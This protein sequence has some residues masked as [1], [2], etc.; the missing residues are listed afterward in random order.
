[1]AERVS[2]DRI[3][4]VYDETRGLPPAPMA[5]AVSFLAEELQGKR[6]LEIGVGT[7]RYAVPLQKSAIEVVGVDIAARMVARGLEKGLRNVVFADGAR[8]PF[9]DAT[10]DAVT[11][12][13]V[14]HLVAD[15]Q[16][17]L[18]EAERVLRLRGV[19]FS[20]FERYK[21]TT[22]AD[23]YRAI[24]RSFGYQ[25]TDPG[26]HERNFPRLVPPARVVRVAHWDEIGP[27]E[28]ILEEM[29]RRL[30]AFMWNVPD[31][32]HDKA[33][34]ILRAEHG[35]KLLDRTFDLEV[36]FWNRDQ[37]GPLARAPL[38]R[39]LTEPPRA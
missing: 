24:V 3:A 18:G 9:R 30:Y 36:A 26:L 12:N 4:D 23:E 33:L 37:L 28:K 19:Y 1:M 34:A 10:F 13:H 16:T 29:D 17:V 39:G 2:F 32:F 22:L 31:A 25:R 20:L 7:G 21:G 27:A 5:K 6:V 38:P 11:S 8:L 14:L 35:G 15:W